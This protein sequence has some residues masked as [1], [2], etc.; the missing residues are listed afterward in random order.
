MSLKHRYLLIAMCVGLTVFLGRYA[1]AGVTISSS[2]SFSIV[3]EGTSGDYFN[4]DNPAP[5]TSSGN[6]ATETGATAFGSSAYPAAAHII[7]TST[8]ATTA[9]SIVGWRQI[10]I[11]PPTSP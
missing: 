10:P 1:Q 2:G 5:V 4:P 8:T 11:L 6:L 9:T 3:W 7:P